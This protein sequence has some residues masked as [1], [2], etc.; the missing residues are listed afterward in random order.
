MQARG[1][2][3]SNSFGSWQSRPV[4][5]W[6]SSAEPAVEL[7]PDDVPVAVV[8]P[9]ASAD[10]AVALAYQLVDARNDPQR[11]AGTLAAVDAASEHD[12]DLTAW[13]LAMWV[14]VALGSVF[15]RFDQRTVE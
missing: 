1:G 14:G 8:D 12:M 5:R 15:A 7:D 11:L 10:H 2:G 9:T 6:S 3:G 13:Y 4:P